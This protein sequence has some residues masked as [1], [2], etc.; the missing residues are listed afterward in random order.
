ME[1]FP[2]ASRRDS[3]RFALNDKKKIIT[4]V[5]IPGTAQS[6]S[7]GHYVTPLRNKK[8]AQTFSVETV[9]RISAV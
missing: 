8:T 2:L 1:R 5:S 7:T 6:P 9:E 3:P 4:D